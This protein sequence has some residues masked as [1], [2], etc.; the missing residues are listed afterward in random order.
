VAAGFKIDVEGCAGKVG[1]A[2]L[3]GSRYG[4][5]FRMRRAGTPVP[6]AAE[7]GSGGIHDQRAHQRVRRC[8]ISAEPGKIQR[9]ADKAFISLAHKK[10]PKT[11]L[12]SGFD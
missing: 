11:R 7:N 2:A 3:A 9:V 5:Y 4:M 6:A 12:S 8:G 1:T 10:T